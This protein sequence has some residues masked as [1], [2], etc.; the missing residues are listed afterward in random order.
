MK[1][2]P[3][4]LN[5]LNDL[6][7]GELTAVD[8]YLAHGELLADMGLAKLAEH[9]IHESDHEREHARALIQRILFLEGTPNLADRDTINVQTDVKAML[10]ADLAYEYKVDEHL[11]QVVALCERERDYATRDMLVIQIKDTE[12][13]HTYFLE[14]QL[15]LIEMM[16]IQNYLQG[17]MA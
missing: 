9:A 14:Q 12:E 15:R 16:G 1:G 7:R 3:E 17:Q 10:E 13:D 5:A 2:N 4:I 6:L 8:Q 11:K